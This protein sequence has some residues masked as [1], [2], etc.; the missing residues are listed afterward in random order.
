MHVC[1][2]LCMGLRMVIIL[3]FPKQFFIVGPSP[4]FLILPHH[5]QRLRLEISLGR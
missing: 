3:E 2:Y 4:P 1:V 5:R